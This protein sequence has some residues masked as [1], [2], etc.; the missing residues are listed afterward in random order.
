MIKSSRKHL[1]EAREDYFHHQHFALRYSLT[2]FH[3]GIMA[4]IHGLVPAWF[5]RSAS[6][7]ITE[8]VSRP[9]TEKE[10]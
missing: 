9:R 10:T 4:L 5:E 1:Q 6:Q 2:C 3:A 8:L 7:K